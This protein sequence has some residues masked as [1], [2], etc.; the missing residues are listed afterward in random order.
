LTIVLT[1][2]TAAK[3]KPVK[4]HGSFSFQ[5]EIHRGHAFMHDDIFWESSCAI[6]P[7]KHITVFQMTH[8][9]KNQPD[10]G[11]SSGLFNSGFLGKSGL[12]T[13][14]FRWPRLN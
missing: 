12:E 5:Y 2:G 4:F 10:S 8:G 1:K 3:T 6:Y 14:D 9:L 11:S 7:G 13:D